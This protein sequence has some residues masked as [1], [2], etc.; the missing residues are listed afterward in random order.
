MH[1]EFDLE[2]RIIIYWR[3]IAPSTAQCHLRAFWRQEPNLFAGQVWVIMMHHHKFHK[4]KVKWFRRY[5]VQTNIPWWF[6]PSLFKTLHKL[7]CPS[8]RQQNT[9]QT[10]SCSHQHWH[11]QKSAFNSVSSHK[12]L[13]TPFSL[14]PLHTDNIW[15]Q[16][17][18]RL[19][20]MSKFFC[21]FYELTGT[22]ASE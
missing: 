1:C 15:I 19:K 14:M 3:L 2:D 22:C 10:W 12:Q 4:K 16:N 11:R 5:I 6:E 9:L 20:Q 21:F 8:H 17:T 18:L 13:P 7:C